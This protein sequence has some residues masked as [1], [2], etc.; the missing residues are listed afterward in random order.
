MRSLAT[1]A[2][3][4]V[5]LV[6]ALVF[7]VVGWVAL[8]TFERQHVAQASQHQLAMM[9]ALA[10]SLD[11][12]LSVTQ[13]VLTGAARLV[14]SPMLGDRAVAERFLASRTY[15][16]KHLDRGLVL[17]APDGEPLAHDPTA[18]VAL[19]R[20]AAQLAVAA[21]V[22]NQQSQALPVPMGSTADVG[23]VLTAP[24]LD[25]SGRVTAVLTGCLTLESSEFAA[26]LASMKVGRTGYLYLLDTRGAV[27]MHPD[28]AR[29]L[30]AADAPAPRQSV[31]RLNTGTSEHSLETTNDQGVRALSTFVNLPK[32]GWTLAADYP[33]EE[34]HEPMRRS[35]W[36]GFA[37]L[38][39]A[40]VL[41]TLL[42][43][44]GLR[45]MLLPIRELAD[46]MRSVGQGRAAPYAGRATGEVAQIG[47]AYNH[48]LD[49]LTRSEAQRQEQ[50]QR[51]LD[52]NAA[53]EQRVEERTAELALANRQLASSLDEITRM[54]EERL[55]SAKVLALS[56]VVAGLAHEL[57]TPLGTSVTLASAMAD[58]QR[59]FSRQ[60]SEGAVRKKA[61]DEYL[62]FSDQSME[63]IQRNLAKAGALVQ[64]MRELTEGRE[65]LVSSRIDLQAFS[66]AWCASRAAGAAQAGVSLAA[67][68]GHACQVELPV[69]ALERVLDHLL[70]NAMEHAFDA[71]VM[72]ARHP[73]VQLSV[74]RDPAKGRVCM[75]F[76]D[77]GKG[78]PQ[79][80]RQHL[81]DPF[82][83]GSMNQASTGLGLSIVHNLM[84]GVL[85]ASIALVDSPSPGTAWMLRFPASDELTGGV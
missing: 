31:V 70:A 17:Y 64:R 73:A 42:L 28:P 55:Q 72:L 27:L 61:L 48:M 47:A 4:L 51:V 12:K 85:G 1:R 56:R 83:K 65:T 35:M 54:Q 71:D 16:R 3:W 62:Q 81:F 26:E 75:I 67:E 8:Q 45:R 40:L 74:F 38:I 49:D 34:L 13:E 20:Q 39:A 52:L 7:S 77:N 5:G 23:V 82:A 78:V 6:F 68:P 63:V 36:L 2:A 18:S 11:H 53:L 58:R 79:C 14:T 9:R 69:A 37:A 46:R 84:T 29:R 76:A 24:V 66:E 30:K 21:T 60:A 57:G 10:D 41:T 32:L 33:V 22:T 43:T 50:A 80:Q 59:I 15:L 19:W 44:W 25:A